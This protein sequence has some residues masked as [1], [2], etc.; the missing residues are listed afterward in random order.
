MSILIYILAII[1][2]NAYLEKLLN[3]QDEN[4]KKNKDRKK[5]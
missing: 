1:I 5:K 3:Q 4:N 2:I